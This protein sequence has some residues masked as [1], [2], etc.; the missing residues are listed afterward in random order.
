MMERKASEGMEKDFGAGERT[1]GIRNMY[2]KIKRK[3]Y[4]EG[5]INPSRITIY[6]V[7]H[8]YAHSYIGIRFICNLL[9]CLHLLRKTASKCHPFAFRSVRDVRTDAYKRRTETKVSE[10]R[11][12][13]GRPGEVLV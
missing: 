1:D 11:S 10:R 4:D 5:R 6:P 8:V 7:I 2:G 13:E 12:N 3:M 9:Y